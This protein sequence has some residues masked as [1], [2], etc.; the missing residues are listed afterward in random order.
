MPGNA[1]KTYGTLHTLTFWPPSRTT[2]NFWLACD[3]LSVITWLV[4]DKPI[5]PTEPHADLLQAA[6]TLLLTCGYKIDLIFVQG[7][8]DNGQ[9]TVLSRDAWLNVEA[10][11][12]VKD[13]VA[14]AWVAPTYFK[15]LGNSWGCYMGTL[16]IVKQ[17]DT[18]L[19]MWINGKETQEYWKKCTQ[20]QQEQL[21]DVDWSSISQA[22]QSVPLL[23]RRWASKQM[24]GHFAHGKNMV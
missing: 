2:P 8:Q 1:C 11:G 16:R 5:E 13:K 17:F 9:P 24:S 21:D 10:D 20:L 15:L 19:Q 14:K 4:S 3:G 22:M 12:L 7:H 6:R 18:T 23:R